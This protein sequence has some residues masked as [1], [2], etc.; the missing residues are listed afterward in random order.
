MAAQERELL[1]TLV[2]GPVNLQP[3]A[4]TTA[5]VGKDGAAAVD[6]HGAAPVVFL[7]V[8]F[9][10]GDDDGLDGDRTHSAT[11]G[12]ADTPDSP[13]SDVEESKCHHQ[14]DEDTGEDA[15]E[16]MLF[17]ERRVADSLG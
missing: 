6:V 2:D 4:G 7:L 8:A 10:R 3:P 14:L 5:G 16:Q 11:A 12:D 15:L 13:V 9:E 1:L 17:S